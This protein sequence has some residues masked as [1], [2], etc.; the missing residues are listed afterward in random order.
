MTAREQEKALEKDTPDGAGSGIPSRGGVRRSRP[1]SLLRTAGLVLLGLALGLGSAGAS[2][3]AAFRAGGVSIG[4]WTANLNV[5]SEAASP[6][7][8]AA[9]ALGGFLA[10]DRSETLYFAAFED[11]EGRGLSRRCSYR[12]E[13]DVPQARWWSVTVYGADGFLIPNRARRYSFGALDGVRDG[14]V[15]IELAPRSDSAAVVPLGDAPSA[16]D[17]SLTL[18]LYEPSPSV[19]ADPARA[20]LPRIR[21]LRCH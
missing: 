17:F 10:L 2:G 1:R 12:V 21:R 3:L 9:V 8:R 14:R 20:R 4:P 5:G 6:W 13:G 18:R 11:D 19:A 7:L 15:A 16:A